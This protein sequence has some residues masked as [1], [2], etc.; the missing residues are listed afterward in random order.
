MVNFKTGNFKQKNRKFKGSKSTKEH[1][2]YKEI[3]DKNSKKI[4]K[5]KEDKSNH[6]EVEK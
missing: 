6:M 2:Q 1:I 5:V 3:V 4:S